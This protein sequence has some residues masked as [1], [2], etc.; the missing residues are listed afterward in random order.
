MRKKI[1]SQTY[2][3]FAEDIN[4]TLKKISNTEE[5]KG[6][7]MVA[8]QLYFYSGE[9]GLKYF[10]KLGNYSMPRD[11]ILLELRMYEPNE[12][13]KKLIN[14]IEE[15]YLD[16]LPKTI[17]GRGMRNL[18]AYQGKNSNIYETHREFAKLVNQ[19]IENE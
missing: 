19:L 16:L 8:S 1:A 9:T 15:I 4:T 5:K 6:K 17:G 3:K 14:K 2:F 7:I 13:N 10:L 18:G 11:N 12:L